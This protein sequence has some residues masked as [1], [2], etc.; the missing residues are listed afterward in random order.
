M[1]THTFK[2]AH[3]LVTGC[4]ASNKLAEYCQSLDMSKVLLL[5]DQAVLKSGILE[6]IFDLL[7][8]AEIQYSV[9]ADITPEPEI[10]VVL[11]S[12]AF[13]DQE[14]YNGV[15]AVGGGS[16]ID[17]SK[18]VALFSSNQVE[19]EELFGENKVSQKGL[20]LIVLPT[21]AGIN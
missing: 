18:C 16:V 8:N 21:T 13:F 12:K 1:L 4:N 2:S 17:T 5:T 6:R 7:K 10:E 14:Q 20:P 9:Y 3:K 15:I 11:Q 19:L